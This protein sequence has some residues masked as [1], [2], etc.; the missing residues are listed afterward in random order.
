MT[1]D[2]SRLVTQ[3]KIQ[4]LDFY[5]S[6]G[7]QIGDALYVFFG[8]SQ[9]SVKKIYNFSVEPV[10]IDLPSIPDKNNFGAFATFEIPFCYVWMHG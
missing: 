4:S 6:R 5:W 1:K 2:A 9:G 10:I 3:L 8:R 7:V